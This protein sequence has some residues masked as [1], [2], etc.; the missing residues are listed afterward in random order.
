[1]ATLLRWRRHSARTNR[2]MPMMM[3]NAELWNQSEVLAYIKNVYNGEALTKNVKNISSNVQ[4]QTILNELKEKIDPDSSPEF[5]R[6][7]E[8]IIDYCS[9]KDECCI[10]WT[11]V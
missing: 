8:N 7:Q 9:N 11:L 3:V 4:I 5:D 1:M 6:T 2:W 10:I